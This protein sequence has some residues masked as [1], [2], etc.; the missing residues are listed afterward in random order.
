[1]DYATANV[2][3][4]FSCGCPIELIGFDTRKLSFSAVFIYSFFFKFNAYPICSNT[5]TFQQ[6]LAGFIPNPIF[7]LPLVGG[8][9]AA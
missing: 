8:Y 9:L 7:S 3:N 5:V 1:M 6:T 2:L 4:V